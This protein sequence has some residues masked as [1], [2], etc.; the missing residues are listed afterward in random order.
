VARK[1]IEILNMLENKDW[2]HFYDLIGL[3]DILKNIEVEME[4]LS[5]FGYFVAT[6]VATNGVHG[7]K[8]ILQ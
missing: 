6:T 4:N 1:V 8:G 5:K 7:M 2:P 3:L